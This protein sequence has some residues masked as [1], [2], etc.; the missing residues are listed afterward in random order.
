MARLSSSFVS[1]L[2]REVGA[3]LEL[4][5]RLNIDTLDNDCATSRAGDT[6][7]NRL[8]SEAAGVLKEVVFLPGSSDPGSAVVGADFETLDGEVAVADLHGEPEGACS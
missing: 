2:S 4:S 1:H 6:D 3:S 8:G 5:L 7:I